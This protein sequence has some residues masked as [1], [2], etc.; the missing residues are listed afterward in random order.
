MFQ[1]NDISIGQTIEEKVEITKDLHNG[2]INLSGDDS[3]IHTDIDFCKKNGFTKI[4]G[5][6]FLLT[7]ILSNLYGK[8]FPGGS[9]LCLSQSC[10]FRKPFF[11]GDTLT[12]ELLVSHKNDSQELVTIKSKVKNQDNDLIF[13]GEAMMKLSLRPI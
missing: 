3:P 1:F 6:A 10:N 8:K 5:H 13:S 9:E 11:V 4:L 7:T 12:F 2:F